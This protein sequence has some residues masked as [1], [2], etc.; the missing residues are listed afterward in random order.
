MHALVSCKALPTKEIMDNQSYAI[1]PSFTVKKTRKMYWKHWW[2][3]GR[4]VS[5]GVRVLLSGQL[6][7][8]LAL[9]RFEEHK[10]GKLQL[11]WGFF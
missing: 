4:V 10:K 8:H 3:N 7:R 6:C 9:E 1:S 5:A 2:V 11:Q